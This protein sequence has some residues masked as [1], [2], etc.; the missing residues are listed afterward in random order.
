MKVLLIHEFYIWEGLWY[1]N[2][3]TFIMWKDGDLGLFFHKDRFE[4]SSYVWSWTHLCKDILTDVLKGDSILQKV[5]NYFFPPFQALWFT[6]I[7]GS[8]TNLTK[9]KTLNSS[10]TLTLT[11]QKSCRDYLYFHG[12]FDFLEMMSP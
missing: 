9:A 10:V 11:Y 5:K 3:R 12:I 7:N 6:K 8:F 4:N 2:Y 1:T